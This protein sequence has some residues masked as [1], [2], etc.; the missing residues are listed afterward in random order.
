MT[1]QYPLGDESLLK[2]CMHKLKKDVIIFEF[3]ADRTQLMKSTMEEKASPM[4]K[5][6]YIGTANLAIY[7]HE[8]DSILQ[9][10]CC[11]KG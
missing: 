1:K 11:P 8:L 5:L 3:E 9:W 2:F 7:A 4:D 10:G 6:G